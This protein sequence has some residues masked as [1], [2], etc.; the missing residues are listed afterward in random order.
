MSNPPGPTRTPGRSQRVTDI[1]PEVVAEMDGEMLVCSVNS[2]Q[3]GLLERGSTGSL[4]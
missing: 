2:F 1:R 4:K 3:Q